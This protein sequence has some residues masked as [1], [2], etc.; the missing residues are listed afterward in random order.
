MG[1]L[2]DLFGWGFD[3]H[4]LEARARQCGVPPEL[5]DHAWAI[6]RDMA[7]VTPYPA[8]DW[9]RGLLWYVISDGGALDPAASTERLEKC[10]RERGVPRAVVER[11]A[12]VAGV[13]A[14]VTG[15]PVEDW[16]RRILW[17]LITS[18][19]IG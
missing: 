3:V 7:S 12:S 11:T 15:N 17:Y 5:F 8:I 10:A 9:H 19:G 6:A 14:P 13:L 4:R 2:K 16:R 18:V 1:F